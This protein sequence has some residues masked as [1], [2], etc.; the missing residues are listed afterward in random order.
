M[1]WLLFGQIVLLII[2]FS[3]ISQAVKCVHDIKCKAC[4][5]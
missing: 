1:S 3:L 2:I 5:K 4:K